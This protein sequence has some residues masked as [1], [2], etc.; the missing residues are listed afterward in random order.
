[1]GNSHRSVEAGENLARELGPA[2]CYM[3]ADVAQ[4]A[5]CRSL[6]AQV[7]ERFGRLDHLVNSAGVNL[8]NIP[9]ADLDAVDD[10]KMRELFDIN[11]FGVFYLCRAAMPYL[12]ASGGGSIVNISS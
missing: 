10:A 7:A 9:H 2:A 1:M 8:G 3:Q 5:G 4:D 6:I 12:A 11:L